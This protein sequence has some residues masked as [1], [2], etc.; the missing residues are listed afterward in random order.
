MTETRLPVDRCRHKSG[1]LCL[2]DV[3]DGFAAARIVRRD[4]AGFLDGG[5][6]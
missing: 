4:D 6:A 5:I 3:L 2:F 1:F